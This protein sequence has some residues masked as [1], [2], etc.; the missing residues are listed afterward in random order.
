[1]KKIFAIVLLLGT[2]ASAGAQSA[3]L[4]PGIA[5][6]KARKY[7]EARAI[8]QPLASRDAV[9]AYYMGR[10]AANDDNLDKAVDHFEKAVALD[11]RNGEYYDWLGRAYGSKAQKASKFK[12]PYLARKTR[13]AWEKGLSV[14]PGNLDIMED[15]VQYYLQAPGFLGGS[16]DKA[17]EMIGE[18]KKRNAYRG[19]VL[20]ANIC[21]SQKDN[22]CVEREIRAIIAAY[23][24]SAA[25]YASLA[26]FHANAKQFEKAF[27]VIDQRLKKEPNDVRI[28]YALGRTAALSGLQLDRG[29]QALKNYI[30]NPPENGPV[31]GAHVRLGMIYVKKGDKNAARKEFLTALQI[32]PANADAKKEL[33]AMGN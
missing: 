18:V 1:M 4:E 5:A 30:A 26:A 13:Q 11:P 10:I 17:R 8:F 19:A 14:D 31:A 9:A 2:A 25:S 15:L 27:E 16:K 28:L 24:D 22:A 7:A 3:Q 29:E 12:L 6:F 33:A 21:S 20:A 32:N 23:P